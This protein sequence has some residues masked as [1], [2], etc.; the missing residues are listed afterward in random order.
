MPTPDRHNFY[1]LHSLP[2]KSTMHDLPYQDKCMAKW[3]KNRAVAIDS[4]A[5]L[6][7]MLDGVFDTSRW[8]AKI[9]SYKPGATIPGLVRYRNKD[10]NFKD[11]EVMMYQ[12]YV[13]SLLEERGYPP[14][15]MVSRMCRTVITPDMIR[16]ERAISAFSDSKT[17]KAV[18]PTSVKNSL[19]IHG[20]EPTYRRWMRTSLNGI[21]RNGSNQRLERIY[22]LDDEKTSAESEFQSLRRIMQY[23]FD[24]CHYDIAEMRDVV[25]RHL[26]DEGGGLPAGGDGEETP[27]WLLET[28]TSLRKRLNI[29]ITTRNV[30]A[31]YAP[32]VMAAI[33]ARAPG[34]GSDIYMRMLEEI[35][36]S[37]YVR[38][39]HESLA[40]LD[41]LFTEDMV[42]NFTT[43]RADPGEL[44]FESYLYRETFDVEKEERVLL[45]FT[46]RLRPAGYGDVPSRLAE[47]RTPHRLEDLAASVIKYRDAHKNLLAGE[48]KRH[49]ETLAY[50]ERQQQKRGG[51]DEEEDP[52]AS[53]KS[54]ATSSGAS[55]GTSGPSASTSSTCSSSTA[56]RWSSSK[57]CAG[58]RSRTSTPSAL[59][60]ASRG[61]QHS[62]A[63]RW[64]RT[65][66][67]PPKPP[68]GCPS[69]P[70]SSR[71]ATPPRPPRPPPRPPRRRRHAS[72]SA[73]PAKTGNAWRRLTGG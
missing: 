44:S 1:A 63:R 34:N 66:R 62:S 28:W 22:I 46:N 38:H 14:E 55:S 50:I 8:S 57:T 70:S 19:R 60:G 29:Y 69:R 17:I 54:G 10:E 73:T 64:R 20:S 36:S 30:L 33:A 61:W 12:A 26:K 31:Q 56:S 16:L 72:S 59:P 23:Y 18:D 40:Q 9:G 51:F 52:R 41:F 58:F 65:W 32:E 7:P 11:A 67:A 6:E 37:E 2:N 39:A 49:A 13:D 21:L 48:Q 47:L 42:Y 25:H 15:D 24:Y 45:R 5:Y 53:S 4:L 71:W 35:T 3:F 27:P 68:S 43:Q